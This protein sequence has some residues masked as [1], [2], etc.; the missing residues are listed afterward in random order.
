MHV[1]TRAAVAYAVLFQC[2]NKT[3]TQ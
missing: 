3:V 2:S 1:G